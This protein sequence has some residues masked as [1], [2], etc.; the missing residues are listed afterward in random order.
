MAKIIETGHAINAANFQE[1]ISF[2]RGYGSAYNPAKEALKIE[3]LSRLLE[4]ANA[5]LAALKTKQTAFNNTSNSRLETFRPL[6]ALSTRIIAALTASDV[7]PETIKDARTIN[8]KLQG[9]RAS[10]KKEEPAT[11]EGQVPESEKTISASQQSYDQQVE[12]FARL[13][14]IITSSTG[15][16]PNENDLQAPANQ[17]LINTLKAANNSVADAYTTWSNSRIERD[18]LLYNPLTGLV[19]TAADVKKYIKSVFGTT[20]PQ[21]KQVSSLSFRNKK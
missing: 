18:E 8:R 10:T 14:E 2:C 19:A 20:S 4:S 3:S 15:Y 16:R 5:S 11:A 12:H 7:S 6:K 13:V 9:Q 21:Y 1:L 17:S